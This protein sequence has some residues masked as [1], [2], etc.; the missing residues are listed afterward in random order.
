MCPLDKYVPLVSNPVVAYW[1]LS[2]NLYPV[3]QVKTEAPMVLGM[4]FFGLG[5]YFCTNSEM[6]PDIC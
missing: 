3:S 1:L 6:V 5:D 2:P 4:K